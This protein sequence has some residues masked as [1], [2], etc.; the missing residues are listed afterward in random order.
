M[1]VISR[2]K[3][4]EAVAKH[5]QWNASLANWYTISKQA[6]W[7]HFADVKQ[8]WGSADVVG[9]CVVFDIGGNN[10][11]LIA[12]V[13]YEYQLVFIRFILSHAE[14]DKNRWKN[15]CNC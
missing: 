5:P 8:S 2:K 6:E 9:I 4:R 11:R 15:D 7:R 10:C 3:I 1:H 14:Y 12:H 13:D